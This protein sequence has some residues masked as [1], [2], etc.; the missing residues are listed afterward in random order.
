MVPS[1][2]TW[3][4]RRRTSNERS[5]TNHLRNHVTM[6]ERTRP[7]ENESVTTTSAE[8]EIRESSHKQ[9]NSDQESTNPFWSEPEQKTEADSEQINMKEHEKARKQ[10]QSRLGKKKGITL[11]SWNIKG[12]ND[13]AHN[14]KWPKIARIMRTKR[15]AILA[16]QEARTTEEDTAQI[17]AVV[18]R[19]KII[20]NGQ[21]S[22]KMGVAFAI[23]KYLVDE[24]NLQH[25]IVIPNRASK[26]KVK[27]GDNQD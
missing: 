24:N 12:K 5:E 3:A 20:T 15:I 25:E 22:S 8:S 17:E 23:N 18:P 26:L 14:S 7:T 2:G 4:E 11:A 21:Y 1:L 13:S 6:P 27:W 16:I 9:L 19:I 10:F